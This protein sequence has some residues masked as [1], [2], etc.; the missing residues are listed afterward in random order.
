MKSLFLSLCSFEGRISRSNF[1]FNSVLGPILPLILVL[2]PVLILGFVIFGASLATEISGSAN[3]KS[4]SVFG[5]IFLY[6]AYIVTFFIIFSAMV[7]RFHDRGKS[8]WWSLIS[9][10]PY[11]GGIWILVECGC[12]KGTDGSNQ[13]GDDP[14]TQQNNV[15]PVMVQV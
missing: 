7:R 10:I 3:G 12:L 13:Y 8:G 5:K 6:I 4:A 1:W 11:I 2:V 14:L 15:I 9:F